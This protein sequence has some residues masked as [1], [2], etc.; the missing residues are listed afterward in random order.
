MHSSVAT[1]MQP[2]GVGEF[3]YAFGRPL[4]YWVRYYVRIEIAESKVQR[5]SDAFI[6]GYIFGQIAHHACRNSDGIEWRV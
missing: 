6:D 1:S 3:I 2:P 4:F 5:I